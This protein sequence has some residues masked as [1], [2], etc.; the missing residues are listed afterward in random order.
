M[1]SAGAIDQ[2]ALGVQFDYVDVATANTKREGISRDGI[3]SICGLGNRSAPLAIRSADG[4]GPLEIALSV[5]FDHV[6][7]SVARAKGN[8]RA[9]DDIATISGLKDGVAVVQVCSADSF[10]P[11]HV[12]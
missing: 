11:L 10:G 2:V 8:S 4:F 7:I 12:A 9:S 5:Q 1:A 3:S 6:D